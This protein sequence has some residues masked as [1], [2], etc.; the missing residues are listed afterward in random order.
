MRIKQAKIQT[1]PPH[2]EFQPNR[3]NQHPSGNKKRGNQVFQ[4][5]QWQNKWFMGGQKN[6]QS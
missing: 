5:R 4:T 2:K 6:G 1:N 3:Q